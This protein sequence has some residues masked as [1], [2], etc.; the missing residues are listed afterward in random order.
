MKN[1]RPTT[2]ELL[3]R[4]EAL[5]GRPIEFRPDSSLSLRATL[6]MA[7]HGAPAHLLRYRA[8]NEP[9]DYWVAYQAGYALRLFELPAD[10]RMDLRGTGEA[11]RQVDALLRTGQPLDDADR[12]ALPRYKQIVA[13]WALMNLRSFPLGL[14]IDQWLTSEHPELRE[15]QLAGIDAIQQENLQVLSRRL[16]NLSV[17]TTLLGPVAAC[18]LVADRIRRTESYA[19]P[20]RA[21]GVLDHGREL[22]AIFDDTPADAAH[23]RQLIDAWGKATGTQDWYSWIPYEL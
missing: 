20:Y 5:S 21:A 12:E 8:T 9:L 15:L 16:G 4:V 17:P 11:E 13:H 10:E 6:Q 2:L 3:K 22:L 1:L 18:A 23:D 19:I 14:R 7:R